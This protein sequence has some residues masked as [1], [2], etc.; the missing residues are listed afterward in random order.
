[1]TYPI[2]AVVTTAQT[3]DIGRLKIRSSPS[4]TDDNNVIGSV[5]HAMSLQITS[6]N[7]NGFTPV[8][9]AS[10]PNA[11]RAGEAGGTSDGSWPNGTDGWAYAAYLTAPP[12]AGVLPGTTVE[13]PETVIEGPPPPPANS[14]AANNVMPPADNGLGLGALGLVAV[15]GAVLAGAAVY[16]KRHLPGHRKA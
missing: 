6:D 3:G 16:K 1:M 8:S 5:D 11:S 7:S 4:S 2:T 13:I 15:F 14:P 12:T 10:V 9:V